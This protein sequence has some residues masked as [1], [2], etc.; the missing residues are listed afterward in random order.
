[1][2][3]IQPR[4][5][6]S[7]FQIKNY[8]VPSSINFDLSDETYIIPLGVDVGFRLK[9]YQ[10]PVG[11]ESNFDLSGGLVQT[12]KLETSLSESVKTNLDLNVLRSF[13][14]N[15]KCSTD[16]TGVLS[17]GKAIS[18]TAQARSD[19]SGQLISTNVINLSGQSVSY[20]KTKIKLDRLVTLVGKAQTDQLI[21]FIITKY[22]SL[23]ASVNINNSISVDHISELTVSKTSASVSVDIAT[24]VHKVSNLSGS[25]V[26][27]LTVDDAYSYSVFKIIP[28]Y[29]VDNQTIYLLDP[30]LNIVAELDNLEYFNWTRRW[31]NHDSF[32]FKISKDKLD[33]ITIGNYIALKRGDIIRGGK[34]QHREL[35]IEND[36]Q[37]WTFAGKSGNG[38]LDKRLA[39]NGTGVNDD[40]NNN[41]TN[42]GY[43][44]I[45]GAAE[46][47]M[48][49]Y[50]ENNITDPQDLERKFDKLRI[51]QDLQRGNNVSYRARFEELSEILEKIS[52]TSGLGWDIK[53]DLNNQEFVF[54]V[55]ESQEQTEVILS[56][57]F[58]NV[59][60]LSF[61]ESEFENEN[62]VYVG[63]EG[64]GSERQI[65]EVQK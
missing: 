8:T 15:L 62:V 57:K 7:G 40:T 29:S 34:I 32:E 51:E 31:R 11:S 61:R 26:F 43:D 59:T 10:A 45:S 52:Y 48:K 53:L 9:D 12:T 25:S 30:E 41:D 28:Q 21:E 44:E 42:D 5:D 17:F 55:L 49:Y 24:L 16:T 2:N 14:T 20:L 36:Q 54:Q 13:K 22:L 63:G 23:S 19:L 56:T 64:E 39:V 35:E 6:N 3:Y 38:I 18:L 4:G 58:D 65:V 37:L 60:M 27:N 1:M 46:T 47:V 50:I 33:L